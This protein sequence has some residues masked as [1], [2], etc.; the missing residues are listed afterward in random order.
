MDVTMV[1]T[2]ADVTMVGMEVDVITEVMMDGIIEVYTVNL[3][4]FAMKVVVGQAQVAQVAL[5][6]L[7]I[8]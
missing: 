2:E 4:V 1:G 6:F 8:G 5:N 3:G 7:M